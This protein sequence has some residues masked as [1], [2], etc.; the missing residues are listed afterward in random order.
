MSDL[1]KAAKTAGSSDLK[2]R[3]IVTEMLARIEAVGEAASRDY[4]R[5]LDGRQGD[6][7]VSPDILR[8]AMADA[9][10]SGD[11]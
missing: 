8:E 9:L 4:A 10:R 7:V 6:I 3:P 2:T 11:A 1:K 5:E